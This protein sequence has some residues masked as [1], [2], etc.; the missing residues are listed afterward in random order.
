MKNLLTV[1]AILLGYFA[2]AQEQGVLSGSLETNFNFFQRDTVIG[3]ANIPQY[4]KELTGGEMW[5][6]LNYSQNGY[7]VGV[8]FDMFQNSNLFNPTSSYSDQGIGRWFI[9]KTTDKMEVEV[10]YLYDQIGSG[11]IYKAYEIRPQLIDNALY[12]GSIKYNLNDNWQIKAF[13]GEQKFLFESNDGNIKGAY[14]EGF[15]TLGK[16]E[17]PI[18]LAPGLGVVNRTLGDETVNSLL[19]TIKNYEEVDQVLPAYNTFASTIYNTLTYNG[20]TWYAEAALK[21]SEVFNNPDSLRQSAI[22]NPTLGK[23]VKDIGS[24]LYSSIGISIG[25][26]GLTIEGKRTENFDFRADPTLRLNRGLINYIPPM[27]R[28]NTYRLTSRYNP[29]TQ[30]LSEKAFQIDALY[31]FNKSISASVNY[32]NISRLDGLKLYDE[33]YVEL[34]YKKGTKW[35]L[36]GGLQLQ[37]YNQEVYELKP[38]VDL[39]KTVTPFVD[40]LYKFTRKKSIRIESQYM[41]TNQDYGSWAYALTE[42]GLAPHWLFE[43]SGM[44]NISPNVN[45]T[46]IPINE[47]GEK[48]K[49]LYPTVGAVYINKGNRFSLR[50]VKQVEG[51][52]CNGGVCRLEPAFSGL[53]FNL[54]SNF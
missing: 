9:R 46:E 53:R 6:N 28:L 52:V 17:A 48:R 15:H 10:G 11:L 45:K 18:T 4:D 30:L 3:A 16:E 47:A 7:V 13:L 41:S 44:Y 19:N 5:L 50:Y 21:S 26:L 8:R 32:S 36:K 40:F 51:V 12:G 33:K 43:L 24:V 31:K 35:I 2:Y 20:L 49:I 22:G 39:V 27:N 54:S 25:N 34:Q 29:A 38:T 42:I 23:Y 37:E 14:I 1:L